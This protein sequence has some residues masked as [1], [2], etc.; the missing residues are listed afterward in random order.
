MRNSNKRNK[1]QSLDNEATLTELV[2]IM[3]SDLNNILTVILGACSLMDGDSSTGQ[4]LSKCVSLIRSSAEHAAFISE[5]LAHA[6]STRKN[7][8]LFKNDQY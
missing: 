7:S 8:L 5:Q 4:D 2:S 3:T 6:C 1:V